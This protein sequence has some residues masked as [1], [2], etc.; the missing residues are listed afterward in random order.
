[1]LDNTFHSRVRES[2]MAEI[3][4][5]YRRDHDAVS[6]AWIREKLVARFGVTSVFMDVHAMPPGV[7]F[8]HYLDSAVNDSEVV[9][10]LIGKQWLA[11]GPTG[12][13]RLDDPRDFV[14][15]EIQ[16]ALERDIPVIPLLLG[17]TAMP[18]EDELPA[19]LRSLVYRHAVKI[20]TGLDFHIHMERLIRDL[21]KLLSVDAAAGAGSPDDPPRKPPK[22]RVFVVGHSLPLFWWP[23]WAVAFLTGFFNLAFLNRGTVDYYSGIYY[24]PDNR[25]PINFLLVFVPLIILSSLSLRGRWSVVR[26]VAIIF[27]LAVSAGLGVWDWNNRIP[28]EPGVYL[29][30]SGVLFLPW[31]LTVLILDRRRSMTFTPGQ[32]Q[33][34]LRGEAKAYDTTGMTIQAQRNG[35]LRSW[36]LG[37]GSSDLI[38]QTGGPDSKAMRLPNVLFNASRIKAIQNVLHREA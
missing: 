32:L 2:A 34:R 4:I 38:V 3:F 25:V 28:A 30:I 31:L 8:R 35:L 1:M 11:S 17:G 12:Q 16:A 7:D 14:R 37:L 18:G 29:A 22:T 23:I 21:E 10:V 33:V 20:D 15:I 24:A 6:A 36:I 5:S 19:C 27:F 26:Y 13:S 9:L